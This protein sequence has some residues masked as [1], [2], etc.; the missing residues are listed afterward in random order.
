METLTKQQEMEV[1][2]KMAKEFLEYRIGI[3]ATHTNVH[4]LALYLLNFENEVEHIV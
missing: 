3:D 4:R 1:I 2:K